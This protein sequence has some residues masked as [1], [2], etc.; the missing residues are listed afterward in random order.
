MASLVRLGNWSRAFV[1]LDPIRLGLAWT[2]HVRHD[3]A[4]QESVAVTQLVLA[5]RDLP[6]HHAA[7]LWSRGCRAL[8]GKQDQ[9][10]SISDRLA[11]ADVD[12]RIPPPKALV[13]LDHAEHGV[14]GWSLAEVHPVDPSA[15]ADLPRHVRPEGQFAVLLNFGN[16]VSGRL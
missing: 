8:L 12:Q 14:D 5:D 4:R 9:I 16:R 6:R 3:C 13:F 10:V 11:G 2:P 1:P 15:S 7:H